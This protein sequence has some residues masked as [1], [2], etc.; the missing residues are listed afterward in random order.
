MKISQEDA[1]LVNNRYMSKQ[2]GAQ[3][4]LKPG[5][6]KTRDPGKP[7]HFAKPETRVYDAL[8]PGFRVYVFRTFPG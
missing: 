3:Y 5:F 4:G 2:Y 7:V 8:K 1:I 6:W